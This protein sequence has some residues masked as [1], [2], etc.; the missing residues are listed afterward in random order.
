LNIDG[1]VKSQKV[2]FSVIPAKAG[3]Q[4][5]QGVL[6]PGSPTSTFGDRLRRGDGSGDF[7]RVYQRTNNEYSMYSGPNHRTV[8]MGLEIQEG[9]PYNPGGG[10]LTQ[11]VCHD[12]V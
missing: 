8:E 4:E 12:P 10:R 11:E 5:N 2:P 7:L 6:D 3:I 9:F 1:I